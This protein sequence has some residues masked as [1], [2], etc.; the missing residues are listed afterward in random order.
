MIAFRGAT[1]EHPGRVGGNSIVGDV[2][3]EQGDWIVAD[4]DGVTVVP[5][6]AIDDVLA[7]GRAREAKEAK[8]FEDSAPAARPS[9]CLGLDTTPITRELTE[10]RAQSTTTERSTSPR[11]ILWNASSTSSRPIVSDDESVEREPA[12]EVQVDE[13]REVTRRQAVAVPRRLERAAAAEEVDH[14][15]VGQRH[16]GG[17]HAHLYDGAREVTRVERLLQHFGPADRLDAHVGA[18]AVGG[19]AH[20][21]D[22]VGLR[23]VDHVRRPELLRPFELPGVEIHGDD[24]VRARQPGPGDRGVAHA[25]ATEHGHRVVAADVAGVRRRAE[26]GHHAA[27]EQPGGGG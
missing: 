14:R 18:V 25:A 23:R 6:A 22:R 8:Y 21:L 16:V 13:R 2:Q 1:K 3:V 26:A 12:L 24:R 10:P 19:G 5:H 9:S 15:D 27:P 11:S 7:A 20:G 4:A 17:G